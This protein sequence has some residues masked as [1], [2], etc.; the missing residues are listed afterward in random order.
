MDRKLSPQTEKDIFALD[1][2]TRNVVGMLIH[3]ENE[4]CKVEEYVSIPHDQRS[5]ADGQIEDIALTAKT[6]MAVKSALEEK[7]GM[8]FSRVAIA[9][10]GR[11]LLTR[12]ASAVRK[13]DSGK[14]IAEDMVRA[15]EL[16]AVTTAQEELV[17][18]DTE[19]E[20]KSSRTYYCVGHTVVRYLLDDYPIQTLVGHRGS[21]M[22]A[23]LIAA[24]L[25][26]IVVESLYS[27]VDMC[28]LTAHSMTLE[29]IAAMNVMI[30]KEL[31]LINI[32]LADIGA[33]T[34]DIAIS[35]KG[36]I[37]AY[38]MA[39]VAGDEITED[40]VQQ[41]LVDFGTAERMKLSAGDEK[42][43][44]TDILGF[45]HCI[46]GDELIESIDGSVS[47]LA[48]TIAEN[49]RESNGGSP[50]AVFLVGGG[51]LIPGLSEKI[52]GEL[53]IPP[54]RVAVGGKNL[55]CKI[56]ID[57]GNSISPEFV[58][59]VGIG[60][61]AAMHTGYDFSVVTLNSARFRIF[62]TKRISCAEMLMQ[63]GFKA[64]QIIGRS[65][66]GL[67]FTVNGE[68]RNIH[69]ETGIP[70]QITV[71]GERV[72][73]DYVI[74]PGDNIMFTPAVSGK[75]AVMTVAELNGGTVN[76]SG[77]I[78][79]DGEEYPFGA[80]TEVNGKEVS[81]D[82]RLQNFDEVTV[83]NVGT[84]GRMCSLIGAD[85]LYLN[86]R[87]VDMS[88]RFTDGQVFTT[89]HSSDTENEPLWDGDDNAPRHSTSNKAREYIREQE[90]ARQASFPD[91]EPQE[92]PTKE[93][94]CTVDSLNVQADMSNITEPMQNRLKE[95]T[96]KLKQSSI[97]E[98]VQSETADTDEFSVPTEIILNGKPLTLP[99]RDD[100]TAHTFLELMALAD[101]D[102]D[103]APPSGN[104]ILT[105][106][107][108]N[109]S[110]MDELHSGNEIVIRWAEK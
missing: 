30:P 79:I 81:G 33:G 12:Q 71:N 110:F 6:V 97:L 88:M 76:A 11:A 78:I 84:V 73:L 90:R 8:S 56:E 9:A 103:A 17:G 22:K 89:S 101:I 63:A 80:V 5:M 46:S 93:P 40:I 74:K 64:N 102:M 60:I 68:R 16:E 50:A 20:E 77:H 19:N 92:D 94:Y 25:P 100:R 86:G 58:T 43:N 70:S 24:F 21:E 53:E 75:N 26:S 62:D 59:P 4:T 10:A 32:A 69:G 7:C 61:T 51:S 41:Y 57:G 54:E 29:P 3:Y 44:Y 48:R 38:A 106:N 107:G 67:S 35:Q 47:T 99:A 83:T 96:D 65:G 104:M 23:E 2:G 82:Y 52:A 66:R 1:I 49:I 45:E 34:A 42:I 55:R 27:V 105:I 85:A 98:T 14:P 28:G 108:K 91:V 18:T 109:A 15:L 36:S 37:A 87:A 72:A 39:T 95:M 13:L 31:R